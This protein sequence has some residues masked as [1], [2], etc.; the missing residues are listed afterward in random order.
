MMLLRLGLIKKE[1]CRQLTIIAK[2]VLIENTRLTLMCY[3]RDP[4]TADLDTIGLQPL[5]HLIPH[6]LIQFLQQ[7]L[8]VFSFG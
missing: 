8:L 2:F 5:V 7:I 1:R 4:D 6:G 3:V